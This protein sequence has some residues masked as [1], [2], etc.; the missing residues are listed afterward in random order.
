[1]NAPSK[2]GGLNL[3]SQ[4]LRMTSARIERAN[5]ATASSELASIV[6]ATMRCPPSLPVAVAT[7]ASAFDT[8]MSATV[9]CSYASRFDAMATNADPTPPDPT[10]KTRMADKVAQ[11]FDWLPDEGYRH[12]G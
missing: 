10:T 11:W 9:M 1:L 3:G 12:V 8:S 6:A 7:A 2:I 4:A 5:S